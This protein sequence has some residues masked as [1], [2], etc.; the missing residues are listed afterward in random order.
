MVLT[1]DSCEGASR[2]LLYY[3]RFPLIRP[4]ASFGFLM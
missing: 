2:V 1:F 3:A 4:E